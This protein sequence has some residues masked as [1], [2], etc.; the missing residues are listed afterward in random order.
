MAH[1]MGVSVSQVSRVRSGKRNIN[2]KFIVGALNAF[3]RFSFDELFHIARE[4]KETRTEMV[5]STARIEGATR[6]TG[7]PLVGNVCWGTH[8]CQFYQTKEDL[9]EILIPYFRAGL[10]NNE[11]CM[12]VTSEPLTVGDAK[13]AL[14]KAVNNLDQYFNKGQIEIVDAS[15]RYTKSG[16][17]EPDRVL[18]SWLEKEHQALRRGFD[19]LRLAGNTSWLEKRDWRDFANYETTVDNV[20][21]V[22]GNYRMIAV[23]SY[24]VE[25]CGA[26]EI[27]DVVKNH[28][29]ALIK[30]EGKWEIVESAERK[31][32]EEE[33]RHHVRREEALHAIAATVSQTSDLEVMLDSAVEKVM[34]TMEVDVAVIS[35]LDEAVG[36]SVIKAHRG[37]SQE[38][39]ASVDRMKYEPDELE[40]ILGWR[41]Q[42]APPPE[43]VLNQPNL[44]RLMTA[45]V[46][47]GL[48]S[49]L[50]VRI[51]ARGF[52]LGSMSVGYRQ[53]REFTSE[54]VDLLTA[55]AN[56]IA[57]GIENAKLFEQIRARAQELKVSE[58]RYRGLVENINDGYMVVL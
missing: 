53:P 5:F 12:W 55:I 45:A 15:Q 28:Q 31:R 57:V 18:Q 23:C 1:A 36:E 54:D 51:L 2:Q 34:Q 40:R 58:A 11:F 49:N 14:A 56:Q 27:A 50:L 6:K 16:E 48:V 4:S 38:F 43:K 7:I 37:L 44:E 46:K 9:V 42:V 8:L 35:C 22:I 13:E 17:F 24:S 41:D 47:E 52:F 25:K 29:M 19:G 3:P 30:R 10:E 21:G 39:I 20:I 26:A 33:M 32:A